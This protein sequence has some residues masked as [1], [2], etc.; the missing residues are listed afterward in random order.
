MSDIYFESVCPAVWDQIL[1]PISQMR[2]TSGTLKLFPIYL[3]GED[4]FGLTTSAV[5]RI[6]ESVRFHSHAVAYTCSD[7]KWE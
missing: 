3:K 1:A 2:S 5:T 6:I 7:R 4:L